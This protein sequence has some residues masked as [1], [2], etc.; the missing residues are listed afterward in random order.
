MSGGSGLVLEGIEKSV[1]AETHLHPIDLDL[2]AGSFTVLLG[3]TLAGKT[4]LLRLMAGLDRPSAGRILAGGHDV[5][6]LDVRRRGDVAMVYQ[7]FVN[8]PSFTVYEN[9][10]SPLRVGRRLARAEIDRRVREVARLLQL[11]R[12]LDRRPS[13]LSGGQQQRTALARAL[14]K[15]A[16]LLLLDEPLVNLDYKLRESLR[17]E[18][19]R[20]FDSESA[21]GEGEGRVVVYASTEPAEAL[22]MGGRLAVMSQGRLLQ[23]GPA[24]EVYRRPA[25]VEV[26]RIV[27]DP[28][29]NLLPAE[30][31]QTGHGLRTARLADVIDVPLPPDLAGLAPGRRCILGLRPAH[32]GLADTDGPVGIPVTLDLAEVN[33]SE[34]LLHGRGTSGGALILLAS[35]IHRPRLGESLLFRFD[36]ERLFVFA[37]DGGALLRAPYPHAASG[38]GGFASSSDPGMEIRHGTHSAG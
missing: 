22:Q 5:T 7:Q 9:I 30:I 14:V 10:A 2:P 8:Y 25:T 33:G 3:P 38:N 16:A 12:L 1:G 15:D 20:L 27:S 34:T 6:G 31:V 37:E 26:A 4:S 24:L 29:M 18:M 35:G 32:L 21:G 19:R 17:T 28:P 23:A 13:E 36:P 11:D